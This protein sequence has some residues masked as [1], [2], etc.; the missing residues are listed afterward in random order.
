[1][2]REKFSSFAWAETIIAAESTKPSSQFVFIPLSHL[3][4]LL[5]V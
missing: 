4:R 3:F 1:M 5:Q 2:E